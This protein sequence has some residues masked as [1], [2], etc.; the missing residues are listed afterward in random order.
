MVQSENR[1]GRTRCD[2]RL[3][4]RLVVDWMVRTI[5]ATGYTSLKLEYLHFANNLLILSSTYQHTQ[6]KTTRL[7]NIL[8]KQDL[9]SIRRKAKVYK[10]NAR[11]Q[12]DNQIVVAEVYLLQATFNKQ[13][14][15]IRP[16]KQDLYG[17]DN[18]HEAK[19]DM[20]LE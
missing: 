13:G 12:F 7:K 9:E 5:S 19:K 1:S 20:V 15:L 3:Y 8:H 2:V 16:R 11:I 17:K 6:V 10:C 4:F 18:I 14:L